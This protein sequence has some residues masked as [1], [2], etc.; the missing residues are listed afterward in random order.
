MPNGAVDTKGGK[1]GSY[2]VGE[3]AAR[4]GDR[5]HAIGTRKS[6]VRNP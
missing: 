3:A 5:V 2:L 4:L 1:C 6:R